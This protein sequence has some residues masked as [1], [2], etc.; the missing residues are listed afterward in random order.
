MTYP[1]TLNPLLHRITRSFSCNWCFASFL[2]IAPAL[3]LAQ[4]ESGDSELSRYERT[5][6]F[7]QQSSPDEQ[8]DF[9]MVAL[10]ELAEVYIAEADLARSDA[11]KQEEK[12][13]PGYWAGRWRCSRRPGS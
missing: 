10:L 2:L 6:G 11:A 1:L 13:A 5:L 7:L 3:T 8:A 9:A 4:V 12:G